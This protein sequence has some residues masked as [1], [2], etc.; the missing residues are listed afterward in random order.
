LSFFKHILISRTDSIG[1]VVLTL[2]MAGVVKEKYPNCKIS[3]LGKTYTKDIVSL[4][5]HVDEFVN[6]DDLLRLSLNEQV[7]FINKLNVD[8]VIHVFPVKEIAHLFSQSNVAIK[9]GTK[10]RLYHWFTCNKI[11][12]L[13]RKNSNFHEAQ[14]NIKL[15]S[16]IGISFNKPLNEIYNYYGFEKLPTL[17]NNFKSLIDSTKIN[18]ILHPK[19]KGSAREWGTDNYLKLINYLPTNKYKI[20]ISGTKEEA[21]LMP[22][23]VQHPNVT[24]VAGQFNLYQFIAFINSIDVL[25]AASTG[26]LHIAAA[27]NKKAIGLFSPMRPIFPTRWAPL[28]KKA[29]VLVKK[30]ICVNCLKSNSCEC[31]KSISVLDVIKEIEN[32]K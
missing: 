1:D 29:V 16:K 10:S 31:I 7:T 21:L 13:K 3:F 26:P 22:E 18:I 24:S 5:K 23:L 6:Y 30:Q 25:I 28:G 12:N 20:F 11:I 27:L 17:E 4:S 8:V 19:S 2:P 9:I 32:D 14:L 15:L